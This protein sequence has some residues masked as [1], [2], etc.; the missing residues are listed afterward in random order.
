MWAGHNFNHENHELFEKRVV[1]DGS[2]YHRTVL[3]SIFGDEERGELRSAI[4]DL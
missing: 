1:G 4:I 2:E 3:I